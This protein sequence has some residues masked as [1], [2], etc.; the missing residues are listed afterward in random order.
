MNQFNIS[1]E[2]LEEIQAWSRFNKKITK[3]IN[4]ANLTLFT[5]IFQEDGERL[6]LHF[7]HDCSRQSFNLFLTYLTPQQKNDIFIYISNID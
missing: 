7:I 6:C 3:F 5:K 2:A 1:D 4:N